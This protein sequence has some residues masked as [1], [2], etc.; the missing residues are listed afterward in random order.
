MG[1]PKGSVNKTSPKSK[2]IA[3]KPVKDVKS[4]AVP[5]L[6]APLM[7]FV[8]RR[9]S[10]NFNSTET[11]QQHACPAQV[12]AIVEEKIA[13]PE[14]K[15]KKS[16]K[17]SPKKSNVVIAEITADENDEP[18][19]DPETPTENFKK[20]R[21]PYK[22]REK[23]DTQKAP[24]K[25]DKCEKEFTRKYHLERHL[26]HTQCNP[27]TFKKEELNCEV[28]NKVFTR[29]DNLR[30]HLRAHLGE[31]PKSRGEALLVSGFMIFFFIL[32]KNLISI[33]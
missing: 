33:P 17:K 10:G 15:A 25:C 6:E 5:V 16:P 7:I 9:C 29:I 31:K 8:C 19:V 2:K 27:G 23:S 32:K 30:M 18:T 26:T 14:E 28:C 22:K 20:P 21:K 12:F 11:Y 24:I 3:E 4:V 1:R 13:E